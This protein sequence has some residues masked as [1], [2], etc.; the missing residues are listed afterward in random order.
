[1]KQPMQTRLIVFEQLTEDGIENVK[2]EC[3]I[4]LRGDEHQS[5]RIVAPDALEIAA[6]I[7]TALAQCDD[8]GQ[9]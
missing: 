3:E 7:M 9:G 1:M 4:V 5:I 2:D 8:A 6:K